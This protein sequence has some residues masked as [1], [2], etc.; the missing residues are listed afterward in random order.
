MSAAPT[1][2]CVH[3]HPDDEAL[4]SAGITSHYGDLGYQV[5]LVT[6]TNGQYGIDPQGREGSDAAHDD[7]ATRA[8]RAME[9]QRSVA[10]IGITRAVTLGFDD[11]GM[12][13]WTTNQRPNAFINADVEFVGKTLAAL[14]DEVNASVVVT[15]DESGFYGHPDHIQANLVTRSALAYS[16][17][18]QRL[19][20]PVI[21]NSILPAFID[22]A[23]D[24]AIHLPAWV[25]EAGTHVGDEDVACAMKVSHFAARKQ[26]AMAL[27]ASQVDNGDL[28][29]MN[30]ELFEMLFG[31][32][33]YQLGWQRES[34]ATTFTDLF[35][36]LS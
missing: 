20:Y 11:S 17:S 13:G 5:V 1:L 9:L 26:A 8:Q 22:R 25:T 27:H 16:S 15:Y 14:F 36:G 32:E 7:L 30:G 19:F 29:H 21:P 31:T 6:C 28:V 35:E 24:L 3:A 12:R 10:T 18:V 2:V 23:R 33:Y 34:G 4:F